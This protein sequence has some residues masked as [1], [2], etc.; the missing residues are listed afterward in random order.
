MKRLLMLCLALPISGILHAIEPIGYECLRAEKPISATY[1][2]FKAYAGDKQVVIEQLL[3]NL[4]HTIDRI[5]RQYATLALA[6]L[7]ELNP[8]MMMPYLPRW[9]DKVTQINDDHTFPEYRSPDQAYFLELPAV[10]TEGNLGY[11]RLPPST[12]GKACKHVPVIKDGRTIKVE[13]TWFVLAGSGQVALR[14]KVV[15]GQEQKEWTITPIQQGSVVR[16]PFG[17]PFQ[18][19]SGSDGFLIHDICLPPWPGPQAADDTVEACWK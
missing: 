12:I 13:E 15:A 4:D 19:R 5:N 18:F 2:F 3:T 11:F 10:G 8:D 7:G 1:D 14:N 17:T 6:I 16:I 9:V